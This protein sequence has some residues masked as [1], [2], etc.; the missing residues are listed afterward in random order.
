MEIFV[1]R[2]VLV[3]I[4]VAAEAF[5]VFVIRGMMA[6]FNGTTGTLTPEVRD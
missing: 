6:E 5:F 4:C 3:V 2:A 1:F